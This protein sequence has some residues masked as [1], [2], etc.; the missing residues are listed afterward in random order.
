MRPY[1][2]VFFL[3]GYT[4]V[5]VVFDNPAGRGNKGCYSRFWEKSREQK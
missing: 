5:G 1:L 3:S 2:H 4:W